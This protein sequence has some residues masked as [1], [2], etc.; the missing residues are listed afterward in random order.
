MTASLSLVLILVITFLPLHSLREIESVETYAHIQSKTTNTLTNSIDKISFQLNSAYDQYVWMI[1]PSKN[2]N[3]IQIIFN[4]LSIASSEFKIYEQATFNI[5]F[6]CVACGSIA[7]PPPFYSSTV[8]VVVQITGVLTTTFYPSSFSLQYV[9]ELSSFEGLSSSDTNFKLALGMGYASLRPNRV[10]NMWISP[11]TTMEWVVNIPTALSLRFAFASIVLVDDTK[12]CLKIYDGLT[13]SYPLLFSSCGFPNN[14]KYWL[15]ASSTSA[16]IVYSTGDLVSTSNFVINYIGDM[17]LYNCGSFLSPDKLTGSSM[18]IVDGSKSTTTMQ[19]GISCSWHIS[20]SSFS[21]ITLLFNWV[22]LKPGAMVNVYDGSSNTG[23]LLWT[24]KGSSTIVPPPL[25][26]RC[27]ALFITMTSNTL[28]STN[29]YGFR[30]DYF[31]RSSQTFGIGSKTEIYA[32]SSALE[33]SLPNTETNEYH[34]NFHYSWLLQP[35]PN[36]GKEIIIFFVDVSIADEDDILYIYDG[37]SSSSPLIGMYTGLVTPFNWVFVKSGSAFLMFQSDDDNYTTGNFQLSYYSDGPNYHCGFPTNPAILQARS[38]LFSDGSGSEQRAYGNQKCIWTITPSDNQA[39]YLYFT[40]MNFQYGAKIT[41]YDGLT[42]EDPLLYYIDS[43][44]YIPPLISSRISSPM[45]IMYETESLVSGNGFKAEYFSVSSD[46]IIRPGNNTIKLLASTGFNLRLPVNVIEKSIPIVNYTWSI[47]PPASQPLY[48]IL[49][50][51]R[52]QYCEDVYQSIIVYENR[53]KLAEFNCSHDDISKLKWIQILSGSAV[54]NYTANYKR[55]DANKSY[56][57][58]STDI[59]AYSHNWQNLPLEIFYFTN[60]NSYRCGI[61][62]SPGMLTASSMYFADGSIKGE[63]MHIG[64]SCDWRI[65]DLFSDDRDNN[66]IVL[67]FTLCDLRGAEIVVYDGVDS[68]SS[69]IWRCTDCNYIPRPIISSSNGLYVKYTSP[70]SVIQANNGYGF[71]AHY[72]TFKQQENFPQFSYILESPINYTL[73]VDPQLQYNESSYWQLLATAEY[74]FLK[75]SPSYEIKSDTPMQNFHDGRPSDIDQFKTINMSSSICGIVSSSNRGG[76]KLI[77]P[78]FSYTP[79]QDSNRYISSSSGS[80]KQMAFS[81]SPIDRSLM[82]HK[83]S[84]LVPSSFCSYQ[85]TSGSTLS[86]SITISYSSL[87]NG[88]VKIF[89]GVN[90]NDAILF[91]SSGEKTVK[92]FTVIAPC[93]KAFVVLSSNSTIPEQFLQLQYMVNKADDGKECNRYI[94]SLIHE[95]EKSLWSEYGIPFV[96]ILA[97]LCCLSCFAYCCGGKLIVRLERTVEKKRIPYKIKK[98]KLPYPKYTPRIDSIR[99]SALFKGLCC[100]CR[101]TASKVMVLKC[102]HKLCIECLIGYI[103]AALGDVSM[104]P[105]KCPM[106]CESCTGQIGPDIAKRVISEGKY[107]KF[108]GF[109]DRALY[110]EGIRCLF[111]AHYVNF[112]TNGKVAMVECP[113]CSQRFCI[114]CKCPWHYGR[115]CG[116]ENMDAGLELWSTISGAQKCPACMKIIEKDDPETC[117]HMVHKATD[118]IPCVR[119]RT[120]FCYLCGIEVAADYPHDEIRNPGLNHF[121]DGV[122]QSCRTIINRERVVNREQLRRLKRFKQNNL[123]HMTLTRGQRSP[124]RVYPHEQSEDNYLSDDNQSTTDTTLLSDPFDFQWA[125]TLSNVSNVRT[126]SNVQILTTDINE[127]D[128]YA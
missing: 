43:V 93:G 47:K 24:N 50:K 115:E 127:L 14:D 54:V 95:T 69:E 59:S 2:A 20:P 38:M 125:H 103:D 16:Y 124:S 63:K 88:I 28:L 44:A 107:D 22:S 111:C 26:S 25:T 36:K 101:G 40:E 37:D 61:P 56:S 81:G 49:A 83:Q 75:F 65:I 58:P 12:E 57:T 123:L 72:W 13:T 92:D 117:H 17:D 53:R 51:L 106:H 10:N 70:T 79:T 15:Y 46:F 122:F 39:I 78:T 60:G 7:L 104:F 18:S 89:G 48:L 97:G 109:M 126:L 71:E 32:M 33:I 68:L 35:S 113:Y 30:G 42:T 3:R 86:L 4:S 5:I 6:Q 45:T 116:S 77:T 120:D 8:P 119:E 112:P 19:R 121:P 1:R 9:S 21:N 80:K 90:G 128:E 99:N 11:N 23:A 110:G 27:G 105:I 64:D 94:K 62:T 84:Y 41:V 91:E 74:A 96:S 114:R 73:S 87:N 118:P 52:F 85:L 82:S 55:I 108:I 98:A 66:R 34:S 67:E 29:Y 31:T 100:I 102:R 76:I